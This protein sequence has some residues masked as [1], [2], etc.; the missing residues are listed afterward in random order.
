[1][2]RVALVAALLFA[3]TAVAGGPKI[4]RSVKTNLDSDPQLERVQV[5]DRNPKGL[6]HAQEVWIVDGSAAHPISP[7]KEF[8]NAA[9]PVADG[10]GLAPHDVWYKGVS[11]NGG[12]PPEVFALVHWDGRAAHVLWRYSSLQSDLGARYAGAD[13]RLLNDPKAATRGLEIKLHEGVRAPTEP[14][15]CPGHV[16][17]SLYRFKGTRYVLYKRWTVKV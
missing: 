11:G 8:F 1:M 3:G 2:K 17:Y 12:A 4:V 10:L 14:N 13:A 7:T 6:P 9:K 15:C 16:R 5:V